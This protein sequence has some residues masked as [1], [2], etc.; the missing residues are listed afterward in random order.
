[1]FLDTC[2]LA[3]RRWWDSET[4]ESCL[5]HGRIC[6]SSSSRTPSLLNH[7]G[8][9]VLYIFCRNCLVV[10]KT[11]NGSKLADT[12]GMFCRMI[13]LAFSALRS[14]PSASE[15]LVFRCCPLIWKVAMLISKAL[16]VVVLVR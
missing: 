9:K 6:D 11:M 3:T 4:P 10:P 14:G 2:M 12:P 8:T 13:P 1:M 16:V 7:L 5:D 15:L